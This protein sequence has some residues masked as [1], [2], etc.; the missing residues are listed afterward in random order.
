LVAAY[1]WKTACNYTSLDGMTPEEWI[2]ARTPVISAYAQ[3]EL[4]E[5]V[6]YVD[7]SVDMPTS[8]R[9][10]GHWLGVMEDQETVIF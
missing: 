6:W 9:K 7:E 2:H 4:Y 10:L 1:Q 8:R 5:P 3:Y